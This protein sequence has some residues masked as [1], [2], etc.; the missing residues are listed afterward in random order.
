MIEKIYK[1]LPLKGSGIDQLTPLAL[2]DK[3]QEELD[4]ADI[5]LGIEWRDGH[6]YPRGAR[7][8]DDMLVNDPLEWIKNNGLSTVYEPFSKALDHL[9]RSRKDPRLLND[10]ITDAYDAL[11]AMAKEVCGNNKKFDANREKYVEKINASQNFK[12]IT[13]EMS[14]YAHEF[15]HGASTEKPK[16]IPTMSEVEAFIYTVGI[17]IRLGT[18]GD[19]K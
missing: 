6:F 10:A 15:R 17:L 11:E 14:Q 7:L 12:R 13:K 3:I 1:W 4:D 2:S 18:Q 16:P 8:M 9:L 19:N 5:D